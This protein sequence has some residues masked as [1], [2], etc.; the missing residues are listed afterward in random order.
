MSADSAPVAD[1]YEDQDARDRRLLRRIA[2]ARARGDELGRLREKTAAGELLAPYWY[3]ARRIATWRLTSIRPATADVEDIAS[4]VIEHMAKKL[5]ERTAFGSMPFRVLVYLDANARSIDYW[6]ARRRR[7]QRMLDSGGDVSKL[8]AQ[9][10]AALV[11]AEVMAEI[12]KDLGPRDQRILIERYVVGLAPQEI[13][14]RLGVTRQVVDTAYSR[15]L[16]RLRVNSR[17]I[18]VRDLM[19]STV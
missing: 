17:V 4:A 1:N 5:A 10:E 7:S 14:D 12:I 8:A 11:H 19:R 13:A 3:E 2:E 9:E 18:A 6:R 16:A 15:A